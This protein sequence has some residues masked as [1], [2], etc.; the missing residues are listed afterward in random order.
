MYGNRHPSATGFAAAVIVICFSLMFTFMTRFGIVFYLN[1]YLTD[2]QENMVEY[3]R[4]IISQAVVPP[5]LFP[6]FWQENEIKHIM[7]ADML[8]IF[9]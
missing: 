9:E 3:Q 2:V 4:R 7:T 8:K 1:F 5:G 6:L